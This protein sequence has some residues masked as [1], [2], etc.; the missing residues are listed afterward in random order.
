M[1]KC[2]VV[3][4]SSSLLFL[5]TSIWSMDVTPDVFNSFR[6]HDPYGLFRNQEHPYARHPSEDGDCHW[7]YKLFV[8]PSA[9]FAWPPRENE[10]RGL[11]PI[12]EDIEPSHRALVDKILEEKPEASDLFSE[13]FKEKSSEML[14]RDLMLAASYGVAELSRYIDQLSYAIMPYASSKDLVI[15]F[16]EI[17]KTKIRSQGFKDQRS[18]EMM[19]LIGNELKRRARHDN[20]PF[21]VGRELVSHAASLY[22]RLR[23]RAMVEPTALQAADKANA[24]FLL[25]NP[26][27]SESVRCHFYSKRVNPLITT[28]H[29]NEC[30]EDQE[31][32]LS[33][34]LFELNSNNWPIA[35]HLKHLFIDWI[36]VYSVLNDDATKDVLLRGD[37]VAMTNILEGKINELGIPYSRSLAYVAIFAVLRV[38]STSPTPY[39]DAWD[40]MS[41]LA[42]KYRIDMDYIWKIYRAFDNAYFCR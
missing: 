27:L 30:L 25:A 22:P 29:V 19:T 14:L 32:K 21:S 8:P 17:F 20:K 10:S 13:I 4:V 3:F 35:G 36:S 24:A 11:S 6:M 41:G 37:L 5:S 23:V 42:K 38:T 1:N 2:F 18:H 26:D 16:Y 34:W 40:H 9:Q 39:V 7:S 31:L 28:R 33:D 12:C 15:W